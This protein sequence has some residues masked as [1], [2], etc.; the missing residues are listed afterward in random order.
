MSPPSTKSAKKNPTDFGHIA[1]IKHQGNSLTHQ[2]S[3]QGVC[4]VIRKK[5]KEGFIY[6]KKI[7]GD[8]VFLQ[9]THSNLQT[10]RMWTTESGNPIFL[11]HGEK[12][13]KRH[14]NFIKK[15]FEIYYWKDSYGSRGQIPAS[16]CECEQ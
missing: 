14:C 9:E 2:Q 7:K 8:I 1:L 5:R 3:M 10:K 6:V 12:S 4:K 16:Q 13:H 15:K 11:C